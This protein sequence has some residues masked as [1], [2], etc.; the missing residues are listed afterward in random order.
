MVQEIN[1]NK[2]LLA[3]IDGKTFDIPVAKRGRLLCS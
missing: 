3:A 2:L 1:E